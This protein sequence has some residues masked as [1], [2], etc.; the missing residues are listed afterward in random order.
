MAAL[1]KFDEKSL[2]EAVVRRGQKKN[3]HGKLSEPV[4]A[5]KPQQE[6]V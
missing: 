2:A 1:R 3:S 6:R 4:A 5:S